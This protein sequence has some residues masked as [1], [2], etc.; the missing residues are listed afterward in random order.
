M[1]RRN[2]ILANL[3]ASQLGT[4]QVPLTHSSTISGGCIHRAEIVVLAD[5]RKYF[6]K[7]NQCAELMFATETR[8]LNA[9]AE[10]GTIRTPRV[11]A[12]GPLAQNESCLILE[13]IEASQ[14]NEKSFA[15]LGHS[16][17]ELH[18]N[19]TSDSFGWEH[20]NYLGS[21]LQRNTPC[22][23]WIEF[24]AEYRLR[25]QLRLARDNGVHSHELFDPT[26]R[27]IDRLDHYLGGST[28]RASLLH[29]DLWSGNVMADAVGLPVVFDPAV[30]YGDREAEL[31]MPLLFG[32]F[33]QVFWDAYQEAWPL[34]SGWRDRVKLYKLYHLLNHLNIFGSGY[35]PN[36]LEIVRQFR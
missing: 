13:F 23:G 26:E 6:V 19:S 11:I 3:I 20:D 21:T 7:S 28:H 1:N 14:I 10:I 18:R 17:S 16:L 33:P 27:I 8:G 34:E 31:A 24:F 30:Y 29:G 25:P 2:E 32:G 5:G 22:A 12:T 35:L 9:L 15:A 4:P 36:C